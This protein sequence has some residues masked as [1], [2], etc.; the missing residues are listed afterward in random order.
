[1]KGFLDYI[2]GSSYL[3]RLNPLT[4]LILA[5]M[6]CIAAFI[7]ANHI[8]LVMLILINLGI[9]AQAGIFTRS[10]M[11]LKG[12]FKLC[13]IIFLLQVLFIRDGNLLIKLPL[14]IVI[15]D[16]GISSAFI[17]VFRLVTATMPLALMLSITQMNDL[18]NVLV[19]KLGIPYPYAFTLTTAM[20][21]IPVFA[22]E[23]AGIMEAQTS[24]GVQLD[25]GNIFKKIRLVLP[26]CVPLLITSVRKIEGSA[27][28]AEIRGFHL[29]KKNSCY[30]KYVINTNDICVIIISV[31]IVGSALLVNSIF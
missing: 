22:N 4:K 2:P 12:L 10:V 1:M 23:M 8:F 16:V 25:T 6:I 29:R 28:S 17:I 9:G 24:R 11:L 19:T 14:N 26:L 30:K 21:F 18:S 7:S 20:R 31:V 15:T 27:I 3:H 5:L 13:I